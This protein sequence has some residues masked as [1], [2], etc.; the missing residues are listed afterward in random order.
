M[1]VARTCNVDA[2]MFGGTNC[3]VAGWD[4]WEKNVLLYLLN[5]PVLRLIHGRLWFFFFLNSV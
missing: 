4:F 1:V 2:T 5:Y 3:L